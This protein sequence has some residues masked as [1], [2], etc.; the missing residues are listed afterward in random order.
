MTYSFKEYCEAEFNPKQGERLYHIWVYDNAFK[1]MEFDKKTE[2]KIKQC[3]FEVFLAGA[4]ADEETF[5]AYERELVKQARLPVGPHRGSLVKDLPETNAIR[6]FLITYEHEVKNK[7]LKAAVRSKILTIEG[8]RA[9][10]IDKNS[11]YRRY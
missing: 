1:D 3:I 7:Y 2:K 6:T 9:L 4:E 10:I 11:R 5:M 8:N